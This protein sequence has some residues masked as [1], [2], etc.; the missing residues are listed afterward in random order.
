MLPHRR[1]T[2]WQAADAKVEDLGKSVLNYPVDVT[3]TGHCTGTKAFGV[4]KSVMG[5]QIREM[6]TGS[7]FEV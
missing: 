7:Y 2:L 5:D 1:S 4:L 6:R 3:Y